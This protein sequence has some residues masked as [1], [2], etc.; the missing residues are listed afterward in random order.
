[1]GIREEH[2]L[3]GDGVEM[4][5]GPRRTLVQCGDVAVAEIIG[6]NVDDVRTIQLRR[7]KPEREVRQT[8]HCDSKK[9]VLHPPS[10]PQSPAIE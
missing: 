3:R 8:Q 10:R 2:A 7:A 4:G 5:R 1:M 9:G 6:E